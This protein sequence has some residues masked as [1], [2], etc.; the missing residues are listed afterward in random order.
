MKETDLLE[1]DRLLRSDMVM[2]GK[3]VK[4]GW[5]LPKGVLKKC[6]DVLFQIVNHSTDK[7]YSPRVKI[8]ATEV[9]LKMRQQNIDQEP[10]MKRRQSISGTVNISRVREELMHDERFLEYCRNYPGNGNAGVLS[11]DDQPGQVAV[12][13]SLETV[14]QVGD[15]SVSRED[16]ATT[17][18]C[19]NAAPA[20]KKRTH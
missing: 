13:A 12:G 15:G 11:K 10:K 7:T 19:G 5:D 18:D 6:P 1:D 3:A 20:R 9:L 16:E 8:R 4:E 17:I 14:G 2:L